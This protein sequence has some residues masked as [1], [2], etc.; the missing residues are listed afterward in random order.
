MRRYQHLTSLMAPNLGGMR[1][2]KD[3]VAPCRYVALD[4]A[5]ND[6]V[7]ARTS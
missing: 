6:Y 2:G 7:E 4:P 3:E 1:K 5:L